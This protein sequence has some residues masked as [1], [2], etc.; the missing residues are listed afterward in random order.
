MKKI[1]LIFVINFVFLGLLFPQII[2]EKRFLSDTEFSDESLP[3]NEED[4]ADQ[5]IENEDEDENPTK[6]IDQEETYF[7]ARYPF[8]FGSMSFIPSLESLRRNSSISNFSGITLKSGVSLVERN[9]P[10]ELVDESATFGFSYDFPDTDSIYFGYT[11]GKSSAGKSGNNNKNADYS[12][13]VLLYD[14][15]PEQDSYYRFGVFNSE[16]KGYNSTYP[17]IGYYYEGD[18]FRLRILPPV[19]A[20]MYYDLNP[21]W[22]VN[23]KVNSVSN[24]YRLDDTDFNGQALTYRAVEFNGGIQYQPFGSI[25][26]N[27][28][29]GVR[30]NQA[31]LFGPAESADIDEAGIDTL[32]LKDTGYVKLYFTLGPRNTPE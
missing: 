32:S 16:T 7:R 14:Y 30:T 11:G 1:I 24:L 5:G 22:G 17:V 9:F 29:I 2:L 18:T 25:L 3:K 20:R 28:D 23:F 27:I 19:Y 15:Y 10:A 8:K 26:I 13:T 21:N 6:L 31:Y 12:E 4:E